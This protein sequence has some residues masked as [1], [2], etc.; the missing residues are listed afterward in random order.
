MTTKI[1][2]K[3]KILRDMEI[4]RVA[5]VARGSNPKADIVFFKSKDDKETEPMK[6]AKLDRTKLTKEEVS[7]LDALLKKL[8]IEETDPATPTPEEILKAHPELQKRLDDAVAA[9]KAA[10]AEAE[11]IKKAAG[12]GKTPEEL[13]A[14][15]RE[16]VLKAVSPEV[17]AI[18]EK[19]E[20]TAAEA[21][22]EVEKAQKVAN[23]ANA[24]ALLEKAVREESEFAKA[25]E[26]FVKHL[27]GKV[28]D[29]GRL[30]HRVKKALA[31]NGEG[32]AKD[33]IE[34]EKL[35]K[36]GNEAMEKALT[37]SGV[38]GLVNSFG[39]AYDQLKSKA[40]ELV[41]ADPKLTFE[42][43]FERVTRENPDLVKEYRKEKRQAERDRDEE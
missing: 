5:L 20:A 24:T 15:Q 10:E 8:A 11:R 1:E 22:K 23:E 43:A 12:G 3:K 28:D 33:Y 14:E 40:D 38:D 29:N 25:A 35:V 39:K 4:D 36:A 21:R 13:E 27:P 26:P 17:R 18:I 6:I 30:L 2:K 34:L 37:A 42:K 32:G 7:S 16:K 9:Q 31:A 41:K 19:A